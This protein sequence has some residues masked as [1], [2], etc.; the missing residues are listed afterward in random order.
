MNRPRFF[1]Q[2]LD[3]INDKISRI[4]EL[5]PQLY[6]KPLGEAQVLPGPPSDGKGSFTSKVR[7]RWRQ[8][9][10]GEL[11]DGED[12]VVFREGKIVALYAFLEFEK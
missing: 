5:S 11:F 4:H 2:G 8:K 9:G 3:A 1:A 6:M 10:K 12:D 7:W